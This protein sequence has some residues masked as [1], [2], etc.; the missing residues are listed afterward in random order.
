ME[1]IIEGPENSDWLRKMRS[2]AEQNFMEGL[3]DKHFRA[4]VA[5]ACADWNYPNPTKQYF[6]KVNRRLPQGLRISLGIGIEEGVIIPQ[7][8]EFVLEG[9]SP[10]KGPYNWFS[11]FQSSKEPAPNWE[12][13]VQVA[14]FAR[15]YR[16]AKAQDF[17]ITFED[18]LM[19]LAL[20]QN[21]RLVVCC[22]VKEREKTLL[23]LLLEIKKYQKFIDFTVPD[24][25]NDALRK[26]KYIVKRKPAY[27]YGVSIGARLSYSVSYPE[28]QSFQLARDVIPWI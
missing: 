28:G 2:L 26:A 12:Y 10:S 17:K 15:L 16:I 9:L 20:Y 21:N 6:E 24:R 7:G 27:F 3:F 23:K 25:G 1:L 19:D 4:W 11:K 14:E 18:D 8:H 5:S 22:E 13:F